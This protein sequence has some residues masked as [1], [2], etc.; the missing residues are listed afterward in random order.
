MNTLLS[1]LNLVQH[2]LG[3]FK[4]FWHRLSEE[5]TLS[6]AAHVL[7]PRPYLYARDHH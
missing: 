4:T 5:Q 2:Q 6:L 7:P 1:I 3:Y